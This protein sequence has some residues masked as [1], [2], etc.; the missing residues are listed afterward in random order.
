MKIFNEYIKKIEEVKDQPEHSGRTFLQNLLT[1]F[2]DAY[3]IKIIHESKRDKQGRGAPDFKFLFNDTEIGYLEN[4]KIGEDLDEVLKSDQIRKYKTLTDNL[5]LTDYLRWIWIYQ[6]EIIKDI[7]LCEKSLFEQKIITLNQ[8]NCQDL[9]ALINDF[10]SQKPQEITRARDLAEKLAQPT[11]TIKE[12]IN[13]I[14]TDSESN[15]T[16]RI[17]GT[18]KVFKAE[19]SQNITAEEFADAFAQTL[20][21]S[22]FLTKITLT[23][24]ENLTLSNIANLTPK[25]F[26]LIKD[27]LAFINEIEDYP[28]LKPY[29]ERIFHIINHTNAFEVVSDLQNNKDE[30]EDA[31]IHFY[32]NFLT[33]YDK[34]KRKE[35]GVWYTPKPVVRSIINNIHEILKEDFNLA[36]GLADESVK[37]LDF[38]CGTGTFLFEVYDKI[39]SEIS[40]NSLK[41][42]GLIKN[43]ILKNIFGF[44]LLIPAYCVSH[45]KLSQHLKDEGYTLEKDDRIRVYFTNTLEN[46]HPDKQASFYENFFPAIA[47]EGKE[48]Q[49][50]KDDKSILVITGNPPYNAKSKNVLAGELLKFHDRYKCDDET[51]SKSI[52]DDY[53]KFIAFAHRK[54]KLAG[55]G[56]FG[57]IVN[58]SFLS[59]LTHRKMRNELMKDFDKIYIIN[60]HGGGEINGIKDENVFAIKQNVCIAIFVKNDKIKDKGVFQT[61]LIGKRLGKFK[62]LLELDRKSF[63]KLEIDEFNKAFKATNWGKNRFT[64]DLSFFYPMREAKAMLEYGK[65]IGLTDIFGEYAG[66]VKTHDDSKLISFKEEEFKKKIDNFDKQFVQDISYRP[67]NKNKIYYDTKLVERPRFNIMQHMLKG[68]NLGLVFVR[69]ISSPIW[70][71]CLISDKIVECCYVSNLGKEF[72]YLAP[73]YLYKNEQDL[74]E[75]EIAII[76]QR[77]KS[78]TI[79][80]MDR[81]NL[82]QKLKEKTQTASEEKQKIPN[83]KPE[84]MRMINLR[85]NLGDK[86]SF[87]SDE[88]NET[89][90]SNNPPLEGGS[91]A[92]P[93][94]RGQKTHHNSSPNFAK[95]IIDDPSPH[96]QQVGSA[97]LPQ[98]EGYKKTSI[99]HNT[100]QQNKINKITPEEVLAYIYAVLHCPAYRTKYLEFLKIDFPRIN[101]DVDLTS[102]NR[103]AIIGQELIDAHLMKKIPTSKIGEAEFDD[104]QN[105]IVEKVAYNQE[106]QRLYFNKTCYFTNVSLKVWEFKI[107]GYQVLDKYLKSRKDIDIS[108]D[109]NHIQNIIKVLEFTITKMNEIEHIASF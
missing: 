30:F 92:K 3:E 19:I 14:V 22:L 39:L 68:D 81:N 32:E 41:R 24:S 83:F 66:G 42:A 95:N 48:A 73:L 79:S 29:I 40:K 10:L 102:F 26:A 82:I 21:Y 44:E 97:T 100:D 28:Q 71:H 98:G 11:R 90:R 88:A 55:Y 31:Y 1:N 7:R 86:T 107:G 57:L 84:F 65:F 85:F 12:E 103:L 104:K 105:F 34:E 5:I 37:L 80:E 91:K 101:F 94:G 9:T 2:T 46:R 75:E 35:L 45:L 87:N 78:G 4:K 64:D 76:K 63:E 74:I 96:R 23:S 51:N 56:I 6:G 36:D 13:D 52:Q 49:E 16:S 67:F 59:G 53:V 25:S 43:H 38:A 20:T 18:Y 70:Q 60:L 17:I 72:G 61:D 33:A 69:Q 106:N 58:N 15:K 99:S 47:K 108:E 54:I 27:I 93:S 50:I 62:T 77:R 8:Q 109:L 89:E